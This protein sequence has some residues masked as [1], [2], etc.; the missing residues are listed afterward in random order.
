MPNKIIS[1][2]TLSEEVCK[3]RRGFN[4]PKVIRDWCNIEPQNWCD[5]KNCPV[6]KRL[7]EENK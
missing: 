2:K 7:K 1:F 5:F 4:D 6:W 3:E